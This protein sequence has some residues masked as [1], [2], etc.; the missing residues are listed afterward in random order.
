MAKKE[1]TDEDE[2]ARIKEVAGQANPGEEEEPKPKD[3]DP[4]TRDQGT[5]A[6]RPGVPE[7]GPGR[8]DAPFP[9]EWLRL[10]QALMD[11]KWDQKAKASLW[12]E[13][14]QMSP[15]TQ[16]VSNYL[17]NAMI[18]RGMSPYMANYI[19]QRVYR[20]DAPYVQQGVPYQPYPAYAQTYANAP[21]APGQSPEEKEEDKVD[22]WMDELMKMIKMRNMAYLMGTAMGGAGQAPMIEMR[23]KMGPDGQVVYGADGQPQIEY[24]PHSV[25]AMPG[26]QMVSAYQRG[27]QVDPS[28]MMQTVMDAFKTGVEL[29]RQ[30]APPDTSA[31]FAAMQQQVHEAQLGELKAHFAAQERSF[32]A[33]RDIFLKQLD[34]MSPEKQAEQMKRWKEAGFGGGDNLESLKLQ[35]RYDAWKTARQDTKEEKMSQLQARAA[36]AQEGRAQF[37]DLIELGKTALTDALKPVTVAIGDGMR[38]R[39]SHP[40]VPAAAPAP[41]QG[42][43]QRAV[44]PNTMTPQQ[45]QEYLQKLRTFRTKLDEEEQKVVSAENPPPQ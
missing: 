19:C 8:M 44:D 2:M 40:G 34:A 27:D 3:R 12:A 16:R 9:P 42:G 29:T 18:A 36:E 28:K 10:S 33:E 26:A 45:R 41:G 25:A 17:Y 6:P 31:A 39:L 22:R 13:W 43:P 20:P 37:R 7:F 4:P 24:V 30:Q 14:E 21:N 5:A 35:M 11:V 1:K 38:E 23:A 15:E 32:S